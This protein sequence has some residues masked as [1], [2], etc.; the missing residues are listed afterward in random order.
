VA[1]EEQKALEKALRATTAA[2]RRRAQPQQGRRR[3]GSNP[4]YSTHGEGNMF[5]VLPDAQHCNRINLIL[6]RCSSRP[7]RSPWA[8]IERKALR[9]GAKG[10]QSNQSACSHADA[11]S[12]GRCGTR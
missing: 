8:P 3:R 5:G 1:E 12:R 9:G 7:S 11:G 6:K 10:N 4:G 2:G